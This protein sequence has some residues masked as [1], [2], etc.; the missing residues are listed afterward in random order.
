MGFATILD[1]LKVK[2]KEQRLW[3]LFLP[4]EDHGAGLTNL[5]YAPLAYYGMCQLGV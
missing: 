4:D 5:E 2:A 1:E 3:E